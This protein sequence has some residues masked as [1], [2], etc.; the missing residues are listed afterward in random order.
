MRALVINHCSTNKGDRAVLYFVVREL[1]R[2]GIKDVIVSTSDPAYWTSLRDMPEEAGLSVRFVPYGWN[3][4]RWR[5]RGFATKVLRRIQLV[6]RRHLMFPLMRA[7]LARGSRPWYLRLLVCGAYLRAV[8]WAD[9]IIST[10]GHHV[11]TINART[12]ATPQMS[13]MAV[14]LLC[15]KPLV[16]WSQ[17]IGTFRFDSPESEA[18]VRKILLGAR[19]IFIR[20]EASR[21]ELQ[22]LGVPLD[23]VHQT[24]ES[25]FGLMDVVHERKK[26]S[27]RQPIVGLS[28]WV[29]PNLMSM[30]QRE[31]YVQSLVRL[32]N[33][34]TANGYRVRMFPHE[35]AG[36]DVPYLR[37]IAQRA[38]R[39]EACEIVE[40]YPP[41]VEHI[42]H[43][44]GCRLFIGHKTH[45]VVF[46]LT[47]A[48]PLLAIAYH[49]KTEGFMAQ[50]GLTPYCVTDPEL[51]GP[52]PLEVLQQVHENGE[53]IAE[54]EAEIA[55]RL[56]SEV[57]SDFQR[58]IERMRAKPSP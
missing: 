11:T 14:A 47:T 24:H 18:F 1:A 13:D 32:V 35:L 3:T 7:A 50:F 57:R 39:R 28:V 9:L 4:S 37:E 23:H 12:V 45:S 55:P 42:R 27:E 40:D 58:M 53:A 16:L 17:S 25:V 29:L 51:T 2:N 38:E 54:R 52:R 46:A 30:R 5:G 6:A 48:T 44:A 41:T 36:E 31:D 15:G 56:C 19:E 33:W 34:V 22:K 21:D 10:G 49:K 43:V 8:N 26:P 20:D